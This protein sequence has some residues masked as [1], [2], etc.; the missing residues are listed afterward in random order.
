MSRTGLRRGLLQPS[1]A[2]SFRG[3]PGPRAPGCGR[4]PAAPARVAL[5][6]SRL[7]W[8]KQ[9]H[10]DSV[11]HRGVLVTRTSRQQGQSRR[12]KASYRRSK[13]TAEHSSL[14]APSGFWQWQKNRV[15]SALGSHRGFWKEG[16][17]PTGSG[18]ASTVG[19]RCAWPGSSPC[20]GAVR[21]RGLPDGGCDGLSVPG[22]AGTPGYLSPEVLRKDPYG[23][24]VD[25]WAC[26]KSERGW[27]ARSGLGWAG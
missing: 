6:M 19:S 12:G 11:S 3:A 22:F 21:G 5:W 18:C 9:L 27:H 26:G 16:V 15:C 17:C 2:C 4:V 23:K 24:A 1:L 14:R 20:C 10:R 7:V 25:L 13:C 8:S